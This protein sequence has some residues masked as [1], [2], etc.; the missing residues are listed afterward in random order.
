MT[1]K[2]LKKRIEFLPDNMDVCITQINDEYTV[3]LVETA[4]VVEATFVDGEEEGDPAK[5][6]V[7]L[8]T[9]EL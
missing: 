9:D 3:S 1:I 8:L 5:E 2:E 4:N 7:F 6:D